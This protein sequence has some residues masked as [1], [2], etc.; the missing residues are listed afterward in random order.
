MFLELEFIF[1]CF[2]AHRTLPGCPCLM[3]LI[4]MFLNMDI[5]SLHITNSYNLEEKAINEK[6]CIVL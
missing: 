3:S 6:K 1:K 2:A 4:I 5:E